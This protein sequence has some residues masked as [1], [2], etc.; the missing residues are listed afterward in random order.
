MASAAD[1]A[2]IRSFIARELDTINEYAAMAEASEDPIVRE[3]FFHVTREEKEHVAEGMKLLTALDTDQS[4][5]LGTHADVL[6]A[7]GTPPDAPEARAPSAAKAAPLSS[8]QAS[9][10]LTVGSLR[11]VG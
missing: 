1:L 2:R 6:L 10:G 9:A 4:A 3:L 8:P 11:H 7:H 5:K